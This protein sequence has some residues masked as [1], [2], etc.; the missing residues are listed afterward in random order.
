MLA[1]PEQTQ[2]FTEFEAQCLPEVVEN[3]SHREEQLSA[4]INFKQQVL[5]QIETIQDMDNPFLDDTTEL[6][7]SDKRH[8]IDEFVVYT[9]CF[10]EALGKEEVQ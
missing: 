4:K 7:S 8:A 5:G 9:I 1:G 2:L 10:I 6:L 3:Y